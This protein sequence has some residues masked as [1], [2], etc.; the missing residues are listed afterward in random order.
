M[1]QQPHPA[2][3]RPLTATQ[4]ARFDFARRDLEYARSEDIAQLDAPGLILVVEKL[5][6]RLDDI[7]Q[8]LD[9]VTQF[10]QPPGSE[11]LMQG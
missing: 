1:T 11:P 8:L 7:L 2:Q 3:G 4:A 5:R 10:E 9:E 6:G